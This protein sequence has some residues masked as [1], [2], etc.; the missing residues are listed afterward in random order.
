MKKNLPYLV[1][2]GMILAFGTPAHA[3]MVT[4]KVDA[5][6]TA[7]LKE[8]MLHFGSEAISLEI[9][10]S[11][12]KHPDWDAIGETVTEM[13]SVVIQMQKSDKKNQYKNFTDTLATYVS[14]MKELS[15]K[16]SRKVFKIY[17]DLSL[18]CMQCHATHR[19]PE[20][21]KH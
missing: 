9:L 20:Y 12:D 19:E 11:K 6:T 18:T 1:V 8:F 21:L 17:N 16:H 7:A 14:Q 13:E 10:R 15:H 4:G 5:K 3:G 2:F